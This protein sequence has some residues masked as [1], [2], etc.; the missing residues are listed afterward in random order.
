MRND[1]AALED[2]L[3][4]IQE[5]IKIQRPILEAFATPDPATECFNLLK[6]VEQV[7]RWEKGF[8]LGN[9]IEEVMSPFNV[10]SRVFIP[11]GDTQDS[12][13]GEIG[14]QLEGFHQMR[15]AIPQVGSKG[16]AGAHRCFSHCSRGEAMIGWRCLSAS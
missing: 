10:H 8:D 1:Q 14:Q 4:P 2:V 6:S 13:M 3:L 7:S 12:C 9:P 15:P 5:K 11:A 16:D